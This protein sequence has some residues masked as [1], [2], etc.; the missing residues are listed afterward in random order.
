[1]LLVGVLAVGGLP[2]GWVVLVT[3]A[4][5]AGVGMDFFAM[6]IIVFAVSTT[7]A[8]INLTTVITMRPRA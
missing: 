7:V 4:D 1:M 2:V 5:Q 3:I 6:A 8:S